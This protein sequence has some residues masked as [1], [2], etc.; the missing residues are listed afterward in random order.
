MGGESVQGD[1]N[2]QI[3]GESLM[4]VTF[5]TGVFISHASNSAGMSAALALQW[6]RW[7]ESYAANLVAREVRQAVQDYQRSLGA[8]EETLRPIAERCLAAY[9]RLQGLSDEDWDI[10]EPTLDDEIATL[11]DLCATDEDLQ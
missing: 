8:S 9:R 3:T 11:H 7:V 1:A 10:I 6:W 2:P 5:D 4:A